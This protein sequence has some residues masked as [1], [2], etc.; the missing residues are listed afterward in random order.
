MK[1]LRYFK[2]LSMYVKI[3]MVCYFKSLYDEMENCE[4]KDNIKVFVMICFVIY[5]LNLE[6]KFKFDDVM[7]RFED[8][9]NRECFRKE[10]R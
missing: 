9:M 1:K 6:M 8:L 3:R 10:G 5:L 2:L 4:R 7:L